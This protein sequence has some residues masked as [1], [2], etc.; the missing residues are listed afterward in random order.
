MQVIG[1]SG[2]AATRRADRAERRERILDPVARTSEIL[3]GV[4]MALTFTGTLSAAT[5]GREEI[6]TLLVG[7][8]ACNIAWGLVDAVMFLMSALTERGHGILTVHAVRD[9]ETVHEAHRAIVAA[10]PP[11]LASILTQDDL[12]RVR[13]GL[14]QIPVLPDKPRLTRQ[15]WIGALAV[16]LLVFLS[17]LPIVFPFMVFRTVPLAVRVSNLIAIL[18]LFVAGYRVAGHGGY[19]RWRAGFAVALIGVLLVSIAIALGG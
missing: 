13:R 9:A 4:I 8:I 16:F 19:H 12:E 6:R 11:V 5:A 3:F 2:A 14:L 10:V 1:M 17:T 15:D 7:I 18:I